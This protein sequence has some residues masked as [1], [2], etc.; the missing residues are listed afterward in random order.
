MGV[1]A[2]HDHVQDTTKKRTV[3][4]EKKKSIYTKKRK[5]SSEDDVSPF[6]FLW[7]SGGAGAGQV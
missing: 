5:Y 4:N 1:E 7:G 6:Y 3:F 2:Q